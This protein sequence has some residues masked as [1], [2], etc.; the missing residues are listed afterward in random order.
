MGDSVLSRVWQRLTA[1]QEELQ[2]MELQSLVK[3]TG[4]DSV[5]SCVDRQRVRLHGTI[6]S[7]TLTPRQGYPWLQVVLDDGSGEVTL[8]WMGRHKIP[9]VAAGTQMVVEGRVACADGSRLIF[10]PK[11]ELIAS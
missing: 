6:T 2:S 9:G 8:V 11:Y 4:A 3:K 7:V 5:G 10:N 1:S